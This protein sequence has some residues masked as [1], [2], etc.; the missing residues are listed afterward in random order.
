VA[1]STLGCRECPRN[2]YATTSANVAKF[3]CV[4]CEKER[5]T[6][7][8]V[9]TPVDDVQ[10]NNVTA[11]SVID[12]ISTAKLDVFDKNPKN[13]NACFC[14]GTTIAERASAANQY[15]EAK[16]DKNVISVYGS[17]C[18]AWDNVKGNPYKDYCPNDVDVCSITGNWCLQNWC[19]INDPVACAARG[20]DVSG[21]TVFSPP[22]GE[23]TTYYS[24]G[25]CG[26][27]DCCEFFSYFFF[28]LY[29]LSTKLFPFVFFIF[30][31]FHIFLVHLPGQ[32]L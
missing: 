11:G 8:S 15:D 3:M 9:P 26:Y 31:F 23:V 20:F 32:Y 21:G 10:S 27:P 16:Y 6:K 19:F 25:I 24:Y 18:K 7:S 29:S 13:D 22:S 4:G 14:R 1:G 12:A 2:T 28:F 30:F 17:T 5:T